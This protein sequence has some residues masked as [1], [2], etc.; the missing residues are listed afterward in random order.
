M[1]FAK[2]I[3]SISSKMVILFFEFSQ[4][5]RE[6]TNYFTLSNTL[7]ELSTVNILKTG[8]FQSRN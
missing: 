1:Y 7:R 2:N 8:I 6:M 5:F 4:N 3:N